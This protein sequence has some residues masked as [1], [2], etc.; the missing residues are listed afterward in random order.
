VGR[1]VGWRIVQQYMQRQGL[2]VEDLAVDNTAYID[3][4]R[5][6]KYNAR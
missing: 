1:W 5:L 2:T 3:V 6:S 4:L